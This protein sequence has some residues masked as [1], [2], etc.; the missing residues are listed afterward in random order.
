MIDQYQIK[1]DTIRDLYALVRS[2]LPAGTIDRWE[3]DFV[4]PDGNVI[5]YAYTKEVFWESCS[6]QVSM[7]WGHDGTYD[8]VFHYYLGD[9]ICGSSN[10]N[11]D[12]EIFVRQQ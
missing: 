4:D 5:K 11:L 8:N 2:P 7:N 3:H 1:T 12:H 6:K 10:Y 9:W